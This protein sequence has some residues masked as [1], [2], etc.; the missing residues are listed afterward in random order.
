MKRILIYGIVLS[1]VACG[2]QKEAQLDEQVKDTLV[3]VVKEIREQDTIKN[4]APVKSIHPCDINYLNDLQANIDNLSEEKVIVFLKTFDDSCFNNVEYLQY[5]NELLFE[6]LNKDTEL[7]IS[8]ISNNR[9]EL[10]FKSICSV[11]ES[12]ISDNIDL[13]NLIKQVNDANG[14]V[15]IKKE[16]TACLNEA[17]A[18]YNGK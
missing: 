10:D 5:F 12:P 9:K 16:I 14:N 8:T 18:K 4:V 11:L 6:I 1:I 2:K 7:V 15:D 3:S 17:L 13:S